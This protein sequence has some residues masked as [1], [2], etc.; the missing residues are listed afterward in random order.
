MGNMCP[1][2]G[3]MHNVIVN[4]LL[5]PT[6]VTESL[7]RGRHLIQSGGYSSRSL[8]STLWTAP[9]VTL[10]KTSYLIVVSGATWICNPPPA[11]PTAAI[12]AELLSLWLPFLGRGQPDPQ[13][14]HLWRV[15]L[16]K[17]AHCGPS[18]L[19]QA[20]PW[21]PGPKSLPRFRGEQ[22]TSGRGSQ[23][24]ASTASDEL[25]RSLPIFHMK[26]DLYNHPSTWWQATWPNSV[27]SSCQALTPGHTYINVWRMD[28]SVR[29]MPSGMWVGTWVFWDWLW[30]WYWSISGSQSHHPKRYDAEI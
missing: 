25:R 21:K 24:L 22:S 18:A 8:S 9:P 5:A 4:P 23:G 2:H 29:R 17:T 30:F 10:S 28:T 19:S 27:T 15:M 13:P 1:D 26:N 16:T 6:T 12:S 3:R 7:Q 11:A 14:S 20:K